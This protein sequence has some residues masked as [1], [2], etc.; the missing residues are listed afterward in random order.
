MPQRAT[1]KRTQVLQQQKERVRE[2]ESERASEKIIKP[3]FSAFVSRE[4]QYEKVSESDRQNKVI[5]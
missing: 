2:R 5:I 4:R 3:K 1:S